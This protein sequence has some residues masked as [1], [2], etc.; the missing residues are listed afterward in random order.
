MACR[1]LNNRYAS[2]GYV[3]KEIAWDDTFLNKKNLKFPP[4]GDLCKE[5]LEKIFEEINLNKI[6]RQAIIQ[7]Y[8]EI[9]IYNAA[10]ATEKNILAPQVK[11]QSSFFD[12]P[13]ITYPKFQPLI[14]E[15][16]VWNLNEDNMLV[17]LGIRLQWFGIN[18][19]QYKKFTNEVEDLCENFGLRADDIL[20]NPSNIGYH[21]VLGLRIIDY[22][23]I[24]EV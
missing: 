20:K 17:Y 13:S 12:L 18:Y 3:I 4:Y 1:E 5:E 21:P 10:N 14:Q 24:E 16:E 7:Q 9:Y 19:S 11:I 6:A 8:N 23:L 22:G 15:E 2:E